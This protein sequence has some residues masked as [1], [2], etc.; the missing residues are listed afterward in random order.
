MGPLFPLSPATP[1]FSINSNSSSYF[2]P[3][4]ASSTGV[5]VSNGTLSRNH[6]RDSSSNG[7]LMP[8]TPG[9]ASA[10]AT[11]GATTPRANIVGNLLPNGGGPDPDSAPQENMFLCLQDLFYRIQ[12]HSKKTQFFTPTAFVAK[13]KKENELFRS[14]MHQDAHEFLMFIISSISEDIEADVKKNQKEIEDTLP[15]PALNGSSGAI[16]NDGVNGTQTHG[17]S[18]VGKDSAGHAATDSSSEVSMTTN[19]GDEVR[20]RIN[21]TDINS[22]STSSNRR[23]SSQGARGGGSIGDRSSIQSESTIPKSKEK[24]WVQKLFEG[25]L[26]NEIKCLTCEKTTNRAES[27]MDLSLDIEQNS[28]VTSCLR[29]FSAS[30]MLCHKDKFYCDECCGLQEA[31]KRMK[32]QVLPN[33]LSLHLKRFKYQEALQKYVKLSYRVS[34]PLELRLFNTVDDMDD[35]DRIYDLNAFVVHIGSGPHHGHYV[36][37]VKHQDRWLL[38]DDETVETIEESDIHKYFGDSAQLGSGYVL[39]Y[40]ARD[41]DMNTIAPMEWVQQQLQH[42]AMPTTLLTPNVNGSAHL[43]PELDQF[44]GLLPHTQQQELIHQQLTASGRQ[45]QPPQSLPQGAVTGFGS[46]FNG[47]QSQSSTGASGPKSPTNIQDPT[48]LNGQKITSGSYVYTDGFATV[49]PATAPGYHPNGPGRTSEPSSPSPYSMPSGLSSPN[50]YHNGN[51]N[52]SN[53]HGYGNGVPSQHVSSKSSSGGAPVP[54]SSIDPTKLKRAQS[55]PKII[56]A[57]AAKTFGGSSGKSKFESLAH[58]PIARTLSFIFILLVHITEMSVMFARQC[59]TSGA[60]WAATS[61]RQI[62]TRLPRA[63]T[64]VHLHTS[65]ASRQ[66][67]AQAAV[68]SQSPIIPDEIDTPLPTSSSLSSTKLTVVKDFEVQKQ[69]LMAS[70]DMLYQIQDAPSEKVDITAFDDQEAQYWSRRMKTAISDLEQ[71]QTRLR[72]AVVGES[73]GQESILDLLLPSEQSLRRSALDTGK[74]HRIR[75]GSKYSLKDNENNGGE[76]LEHVPISWLEGLTDMDG[77]EIVEVPGLD[78]D[79]LSM[80]DIVYSSDLVLLRTDSVR[81]LALE[82][83]QYFLNRYRHKSHILVVSDMSPSYEASTSSPSSSSSSSSALILSNIKAN[84]ARAVRSSPNG[85]SNLAGSVAKVLR[86]SNAES[87]PTILAIPPRIASGGEGGAETEYLETVGALQRLVAST[88]LSEGFTLQQTQQHRRQALLSRC[89]D[90]MFAGIENMESRLSGRLETFGQVDRLSELATMEL[91]RIEKTEQERIRD[92]VTNGGDIEKDVEGMRRCLDHFFK[93]E[94]PF[95]MLFAR[96]GEIAERMHEIWTAGA[97]AETEHRMAYALGRLHQ[98][99]QEAFRTTLQ[100][101]D[102]L[103]QEMEQR[104][105]I[106]SSVVLKDLKAARQLL[107]K[108]QQRTQ[109]D[110]KDMDA[111]VV[112]NL[113]WKHRLSYGPVDSTFVPTTTL[114]APSSSPGALERLQ[115][116]G[117][118]ALAQ[119]LG[120]QGTALFTG[121]GLAQQYPPEIYL[122]SGTMLAL[123]G[124]GYMQVRWKAAEMEFKAQADT[125]ADQLKEE[126]VETYQAQVAKTIVNPLSSVVRTLDKSLGDRLMRSLEQRKVLEGI[127]RDARGEDEIQ[128]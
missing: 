122:T 30:E 58:S 27:F 16:A 77:G 47:H 117:Q 59:S 120:L 73:S 98:S 10:V 38:F 65:L 104:L 105:P 56:L 22:A 3:Q 23:H 81:Q 44:G 4:A 24:V 110:I 75:Y 106:G 97:F 9:A 101:I 21:G 32:I 46:L 35:P 29:Q 93:S 62:Q 76:N 40:Q 39:F 114:A 71:G 94:V 89:R 79:D 99:S 90:L 85:Y 19:G 107:T 51:S 127:K 52:G 42:A 92:Q 87:L 14:S 125:L 116:R 82:K 66:L 103:A 2:G 25:Q 74:V 26:T 55:T 108:T 33:I 80:D 12:N 102:Q 72:V 83:E 119:G 63:P 111:F 60:A 115:R 49:T 67:A 68:S 88:L 121:L 64:R 86:I 48:M 78:L 20:I 5:G 50:G 18:G 11:S 95:W 96:S 36:A 45:Q 126:I 109:Q 6:Q 128:N 28:S 53:S 15:K 70:M 112:S 113:V 13:V 17:T 61:G 123:A 91:Q 41:L 57:S 8:T 100:A 43:G 7:T 31:E 84:L 118:M 69:R 34:F 1:A 124:L 54:H 37:V